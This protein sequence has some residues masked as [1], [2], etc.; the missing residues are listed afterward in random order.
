M[1]ARANDSVDDDAWRDQVL[2]LA[3]A[4]RGIGGV[5]VDLYHQH[6]PEVDW[7]RY[8]PQQ[9]ARR[10]F[11]LVAVNAAWRER[12]DGTNP[13]TV[14]A[15]AVAEA[16]ELL[17]LFNKNQT[18]FRRKVKLVLLPGASADDVPARS[19]VCSD[20]GSTVPR[21]TSS[22]ICC[23][24]CTTSRSSCP[25]RSVRYPPCHQRR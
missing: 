12:F 6:D 8:G 24:H 25:H 5:D 20:F 14:G 19:P 16:D 21:W 13:P 23:G 11:V 15:G 1:G 2:V 22:R 3:A 17:G 18:E 4:L 7:S 10:D 9:V